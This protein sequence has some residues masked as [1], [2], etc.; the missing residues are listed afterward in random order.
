MDRRA[1]DID[2]IAIRVDDIEESLRFYSQSLGM[3]TVEPDRYEGEGYEG[4]GP[5]PMRA[6]RAGTTRIH[7]WPTTKEFEI[8][9]E[10]QFGY[11]VPNPDHFCLTY[12]SDGRDPEVQLAE[13]ADELRQEGVDVVK[14][15]PERR[16]G[17]YGHA[18]RLHVLDPD[19]RDIELR[20]Y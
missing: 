18:Y 9:Y 8:P 20:M 1:I 13:I 17:P 2:H 19:G 4:F 11:G 5:S 16:P 3:E 10:E 7:L 12:R 6:V 14:G 15:E